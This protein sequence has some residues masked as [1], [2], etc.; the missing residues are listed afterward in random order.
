MALK[1]EYR[2]PG[3]LGWPSQNHQ[4]DRKLRKRARLLLDEGDEL[5]RNASRRLRSQ[6]SESQKFE[7]DMARALGAWNRVIEAEAK[8]LWGAVLPAA[9]E[10][11]QRLYRNAKG[12]LSQFLNGR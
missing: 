12:S 5:A 11:L 4:G 8:R 7:R 1:S 3:E 2:P 6:R 9:G 10:N